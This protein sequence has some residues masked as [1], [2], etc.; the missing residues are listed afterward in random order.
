MPATVHRAISRS[1]NHTKLIPIFLMIHI[2]AAAVVKRF[3]LL[4]ETILFIMKPRIHLPALLVRPSF[5][6]TT[7]VIGEAIVVSIGAKN[8]LV[9]S[10]LVIAP[11][12]NEVVQLSVAWW[13][14]KL[15]PCVPSSIANRAKR[16]TLN[17]N[18]LLNLCLVISNRFLV[19]PASVYAVLQR[20]MLS[21][22]W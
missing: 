4:I 3:L 9:V 15:K 19:L 2:K 1:Y 16:Y 17:E 20:S 12:V 21:L 6:G 22:S 13:M 18:T 10:I 5:F 14:R 8:V 11:P 7:P